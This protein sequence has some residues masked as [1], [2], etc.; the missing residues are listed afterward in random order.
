[1]KSNEADIE[2]IIAFEATRENYR[3]MMMK[4]SITRS[5]NI[6]RKTV[7]GHLKD[8]LKEYE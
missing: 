4:L 7:A 5:I 6:L 2:E 8:V 3:T 1:V